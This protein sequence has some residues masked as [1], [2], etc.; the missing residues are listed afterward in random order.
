[1]DPI[2]TEPQVSK[3]FNLPIKVSVILLVT[4]L[5]IVSVFIYKSNARCPDCSKAS[6]ERAGFSEYVDKRLGFSLLI[7]SDFVVDSENDGTRVYFD[8]SVYYIGLDVVSFYGTTQQYI[9]NM[10]GGIAKKE[11]ILASNKIGVKIQT[12]WDVSNKS[13]HFLFKHENYFLIFRGD[14]GNLEKS[15]ILKNIKFFKPEISSNW[16]VYKASQGFEFEFPAEWTF[17]NDL[18]NA[19]WP[20]HEGKYGGPTF[21]PSDEIADVLEDRIFS[22]NIYPEGRDK[23]NY[24]GFLGKKTIANIEFDLIDYKTGCYGYEYNKEYPAPYA[25]FYRYVFSTCREELLGTVEKILSTLK[26]TKYLDPIELETY[27]NE[28]YNFELGIPSDWVISSLENNPDSVLFV[29]PD[30]LRIVFSPDNSDRENYFR[31]KGK[32]VVGGKTFSV[33]EEQMSQSGHHEYEIY[34][35]GQVYVFSDPGFSLRRHEMLSTLKFTK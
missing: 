27:K 34:H 16:R 6:S 28:K 33:Y 9:D 11:N 24:S 13:E 21:Y 2:L 19:G 22:A 26:L 12:T 10:R 15:G 25:T 5:V 8:N 20:S 1:M 14:V 32:E 31:F 18:V 3:K 17:R 35:N 30:G 23:T 29:A 4:F 7:P